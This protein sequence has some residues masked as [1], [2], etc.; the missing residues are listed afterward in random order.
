MNTLKHKEH[1]LI[2]LYKDEPLDGHLLSAYYPTFLLLILENHDIT[3]ELSKI[4]S[5]YHIS[6][7][8]TVAPLTPL[9][10]LHK[11]NFFYQATYLQSFIS[12]LKPRK[13]RAL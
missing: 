3:K 7:V 13:I 1:M 8:H 9:T 6:S 2:T 11:I 5:S 10:L 4:A 12:L